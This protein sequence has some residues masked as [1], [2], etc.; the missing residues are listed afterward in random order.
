MR[1][2][3]PDESGSL[4]SIPKN[5]SQ[6]KTGSS[7]ETG[8]SDTDTAS[9]VVV[10]AVLFSILKYGQF[11]T[12]VRGQDVGCGFGSWQQDLVGVLESAPSGQATA[13][14]MVAMLTS[15]SAI[16]NATAVFISGVDVANR[17]LVG[18]I[19][20]APKISIPKQDNP[21]GVGFYSKATNILNLEY[22]PSI[23][24]SELLQR[25][26]GP[27]APACGM[28]DDAD[29]QSGACEQGRAHDSDKL[30]CGHSPIVSRSRLGHSHCELQLDL[31][32]LIE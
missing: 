5:E 9:G 21:L 15:I 25:Y 24:R 30:K 11:W 28:F 31:A 19:L 2:N 22:R 26:R 16:T 20:R 3:S 6:F 12:V 4:F 8:V 14:Q 13:G 10:A 7:G 17:I 29:I 1:R 27:G 32:S 23:A 18:S